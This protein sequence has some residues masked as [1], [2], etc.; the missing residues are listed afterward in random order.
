[1]SFLL[2]GVARLFVPRD[3]AASS[4]SNK[5]QPSP[6][7]STVSVTA[8]YPSIPRYLDRAH[9]N[10]SVVEPQSSPNTPTSSSPP[11]KSEPQDNQ[12]SRRGLPDGQL[13]SNLNKKT[14]DGSCSTE[15]VTDEQPLLTNPDD[16]RNDESTRSPSTAN[17]VLNSDVAEAVTLRTT[18]VEPSLNEDVR[19]APEPQPSSTES[20]P[21]DDLIASRGRPVLVRESPTA[22]ADF[23]G[24]ENTY[25]SPTTENGDGILE[26]LSV[27]TNVM[28][29]KQS[30][31]V[32]LLGSST[33]IQALLERAPQ[34]HPSVLFLVSSSGETPV[35]TT[36]RLPKEVRLR[37]VTLRATWDAELVVKGF[38]W[39][40]PSTWV[41]DADVDVVAMLRPIRNLSTVQSTVIAV[42]STSVYPPGDFAYAAARWTFSVISDCSAA[43]DLRVATLEHA[44]DKEPKTS[45]ATIQQTHDAEPHDAKPH[46]SGEQQVLVRFKIGASTIPQHR[47]QWAS[48]AIVIGAAESLGQWDPV[49]ALRLQGKLNGDDATSSS[50]VASAA[51]CPSDFPVEYK[52]AILNDDGH[53]VEWESGCNRVMHGAPSDCLAEAWRAA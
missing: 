10:L 47:R 5:E 23:D 33:L 48:C 20:L 29:S 11:L 19:M 43:G 37:H 25:S 3:P 4:P 12:Y 13:N 52:Y 27:V 14:G 7:T 46:V 22:L 38:D 49:R 53:V 36:S 42:Y 2:S 15:Q 32:I 9:G 40:L 34:V 51:L 18:I 17:F 21:K 8:R 24:S 28:S 30:S 6:S 44:G 31:Q 1:M 39:K 45:G 50:L 41:L 16:W 26:C 35:C